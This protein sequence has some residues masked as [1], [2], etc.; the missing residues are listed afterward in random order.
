MDLRDD[1]NTT[2][3]TTDYD[4]GDSVTWDHAYEREWR[5]DERRSRAASPRRRICPKPR[6]RGATRCICGADQNRTHDDDEITPSDDSSGT[7]E[8][9]AARRLALRRRRSSES[10]AAPRSRSKERRRVD[11]PKAATGGKLTRREPSPYIEDYP[12][13]HRR[14]R[15]TILLREH[16][17]TR[18]SSTPETNHSGCSEDRSS[19]GSR[20]RSSSEERSPPRSSGRS[21]KESP[22]RIRHHRKRHTDSHKTRSDKSSDSEELSNF[23]YDSGPELAARHRHHHCLEPEATASRS[24]AGSGSRH[25]KS[26]PSSR[27]LPAGPNHHPRRPG[28]H[29]HAPDSEEESEEDR[30]R[31]ESACEEHSRPRSTRKLTFRTRTSDRERV[32]SRQPS[33]P[34]RHERASSR[35]PTPRRYSRTVISH[36]SLTTTENRR[37]SVATSLCEVWR[38]DT[39]DWESPYTSGSASERDHEAGNEEPTSLLRMEDQLSRR[40]S[41]RL[42]P[43]RGG[44]EEFGFQA[45]HR[46]SPPNPFWP[47]RTSTTRHTAGRPSDGAFPDTPYRRPTLSRPASNRRIHFRDE[48]QPVASST[49]PDV[50]TDDE[51]DMRPLSRASRW[52]RPGHPRG[53]TRPLPP[54][55]RNVSPALSARKTREFP[56]PTPTRAERFD[57]GAW[58]SDRASRS[59]VA[60]GLL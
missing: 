41:P 46:R 52:P 39:D 22:P 9:R 12:D 1:P 4:S 47:S 7:E 57:Y 53:W 40:S 28:R 31:H 35:P 45:P 18:R 10:S 30:R 32:Q 2:T 24:S 3:T 21:S 36:A 60:L 15:P 55:S 42:P 56:S 14:P 51:G 50:M 49:A 59:S 5:E 34:A 8:E 33:P 58:G 29:D 27:L 13:E 25:R 48:G 44:R 43:P 19:S 11:K 38:G 54:R 6:P 23:E 26:Y 17:I 37:R 16:R 20:S